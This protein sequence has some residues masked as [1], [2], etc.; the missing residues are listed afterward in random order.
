[1]KER[2]TQAE[3]R[4]ATQAIL[5]AAARELFGEKGYAETSLE[6]IAVAL[7]LIHI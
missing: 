2:R 7:S 5:L 6:D 4:E 3:R 1:M